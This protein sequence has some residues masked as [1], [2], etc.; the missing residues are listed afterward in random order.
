MKVL[1]ADDEL[2]ERKA[3]RKILLATNKNIKV[4]GEAENGRKAVELSKDL[5]PNIIFMDIKMPGMTGLEAIQQIRK[6]QADVKIILVSA[7]DT[8][9]Y[10][11]QA[12]S[13]GIKDYILKPGSK[14][15]IMG[16]YNRVVKEI[17]AEREKAEVEQQTDQLLKESFVY[18]IIR[19]Q[20]DDTAVSL[21][22]Y[23]FQSAK[24]SYFLVLSKDDKFQKEKLQTIVGE[25]LTD[26][27]IL[28]GIKDVFVCF[29]V[30]D[31]IVEKADQL[32]LA[33]KLSTNC[34]RRVFIGI[35]EVFVN[36]KEAITSYEEAY[37]SC[38]YYK[39]NDK[40]HYGFLPSAASE[41]REQL[42]KRI[43]V[44]IENGKAE[45]ARE[46]YKRY[47]IICKDGDKDQ[48]YI[49]LQSML[50]RHN[51][52]F[53]PVS[54]SALHTEKEWHTFLSLCC[55]KMNEYHQSK[56]TMAVAKRYIEDRFSTNLTLE[57][58]AEVVRLSPNYFSN[59]FKEHF[60]E[61][62]IEFLTRIR[63][64]QAK[65][66][67]MKNNVSLKEISYLVG[68]RDPNYFSRVFKRY[69]QCSPRQFQNKIFKK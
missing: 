51:I 47:S 39:S 7:Y 58:V 15:E 46:L 50:E 57:A 32:I 21:Y 62:F 16:A 61:S 43:L 13:F 48:L 67:I 60:D 56:H 36:I 12:M 11:K 41:D 22:N 37:A 10:A 35:G 44:E 6:E 2:L 49:A 45:M 25:L 29:I 69:Y 55:M 8:F 19:Q 30:S 18:K 33:K 63:M 53:T 42:L 65:N 27:F 9:E 34:G 40:S 17:Y 3:M 1:I 23:F 26:A 52:Q 14:T 64:E 5:Q 59:L 66:L 20:I 31:A 38:F 28:I 24:S 4:V 54:L 68:Y